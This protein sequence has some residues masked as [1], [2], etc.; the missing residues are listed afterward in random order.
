MDIIHPPV[1]YLK[2]D[3]S[4]TGVCLRHK[5]ERTQLGPTDT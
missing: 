4:E 2:H 5:V 1:F 3:V